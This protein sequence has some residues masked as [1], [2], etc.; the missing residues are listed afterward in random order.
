MEGSDQ[1]CLCN[2]LRYPDTNDSLLPQ[3][4]CGDKTPWMVYPGDNRNVVLKILGPGEPTIKALAD[5]MAGGGQFWFFTLFLCCHVTGGET[6]S[7]G[8]F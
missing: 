5:L 8:Y 2:S 3:S 1:V 4:F 6:G 7:L